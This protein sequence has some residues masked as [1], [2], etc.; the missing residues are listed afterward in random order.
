MFKRLLYGT[1]LS[2]LLTSQAPAEPGEIGEFVREQ[3]GMFTLSGVRNTD[4]KAYCH[5]KTSYLGNDKKENLYI[6]KN[7]LRDEFYIEFYNSTMNFRNRSPYNVL[8]FIFYDEKRNVKHTIEHHYH[9]VGKNTI[10]IREISPLLLSEVMAK[11]DL[12]EIVFESDKAAP[13]IEISSPEEALKSLYSC[14]WYFYE[15]YATE[16]EKINRKRNWIKSTW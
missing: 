9:V 16:K 14:E 13:K 1:A 11:S 10:H 15:N 8:Y 7:L 4:G 12:M 5:L 2:L 3:K 6:I